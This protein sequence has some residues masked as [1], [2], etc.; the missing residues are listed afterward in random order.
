MKT[1][2]FNYELPPEA[3]AQEPAPERDRARLLAHDV[4]RDVSSHIE[5][6]GLTE[7]LEAG[8]LLV[9]NDTQVIPARLFGRRETGGLLEV[10]LLE[11][12]GDGAE[13]TAMVR[14]A[15][16]PTPGE[17]VELGGG[18]TVRFLERLPDAAGAPGAEWRVELMP[19]AGSEG[20]ELLE[21]C[22]RMP[23]PPYIERGEDADAVQD[24]ERYQTVYA[25]KPG[26]VA[27]PTA[28]LHFTPGLLEELRSKGVRIA[29]VTLYVGAGTFRPV[30][31]EQI[32]DHVMHAERYELSEEAAS[33]VNETR[34]AGGRVVAVG[35]TSVRVL[36]SCA[37]EGGAVV[38][39][40]GETRLFLSPG[41]S[42]QVVDA[43]MTNFHLP[44][45]TLL[46]LVSAFA[47]R[48]RVL[49]LYEEA[50]REGY[51]FYSYGDAMFLFNAPQR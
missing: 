47:G 38:P 42:F 35:T 2:D 41:S 49:R 19:R 9:V 16:K 14:P 18:H 25:T 24:K 13:W 6:C 15:K 40:S 44:K 48:E 27:A 39:G 26:A 23:L 30:T 32:E 29:R 43:L 8:D 34:A 3:I 22:G 37:G 5:V 28:G 51:R 21:E 45:S 12:L 7:L 33:L 36:E 31:S 17:E 46:M 50:L 20:L 4:H 11:Q 1:D 10:L